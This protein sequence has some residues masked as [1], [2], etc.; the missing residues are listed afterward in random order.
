MVRLAEVVDHAAQMAPDGDQVNGRLI[1]DGGGHVVGILKQLAQVFAG[2]LV[3][4]GLVDGI[5]QP[6]A[7]VAVVG[8]VVVE[9]DDLVRHI[10]HDVVA[11]R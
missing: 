6:A 2:V 9:A 8:Q 5:A 7:H 3:A 4:V 11:V 1:D 10:Q